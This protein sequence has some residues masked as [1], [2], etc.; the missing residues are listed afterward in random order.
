MIELVNEVILAS[1]SYFEGGP[2]GDMLS[3]W[4]QYG[5]FSYLL[6]FLLIFA[7]VFGILNQIHLFKESKSI[8]GIIALVVGLLALQYPLVPQFFSEIFPRMGVGLS[9]ILVL[10]IL[11]GMF[12]DPGKAGI[13]T[14]LMVIGVIITIIILIQTAGAVGWASGWWWEENWP[15][16][17]GVVFILVVI[18]IIVGGSSRKEDDNYRAFWPFSPVSKP[19]K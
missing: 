10:L 13:M 18:A 9:I 17:A 2:I 3:L 4:Q 11:A 19:L 14:T 12:V 5:F 16:V 15:M 8:N 7:L 6:P 1:Y